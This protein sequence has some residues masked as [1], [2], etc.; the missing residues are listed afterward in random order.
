[1]CHVNL[2]TSEQYALFCSLNYALQKKVEA[3]LD[4]DVPT[5]SRAKTRA[6]FERIL[7]AEGID[8]PVSVVAQDEVD[9]ALVTFTVTDAEGKRIALTP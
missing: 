5:N 8:P 6:T 1:V 3:V 4:R 7:K 9:A 2:L